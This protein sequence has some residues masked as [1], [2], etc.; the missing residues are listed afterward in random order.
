VMASSR[1]RSEE[2]ADAWGV[3]QAYDDVEQAAAS[4][5]DVV[6]I[7]TPNASHERTTITP[8]QQQAIVEKAIL[9]Q[10]DPSDNLLMASTGIFGDDEERIKETIKK[11]SDEQLIQEWVTVMHKTP[12]GSDSLGDK[13]A[14]WKTAREGAPIQPQGN[15]EGEQPKRQPKVGSPEWK[16]R[17]AFKCH[18]L[19]TSD[20]FEDLLLKY[21]GGLFADDDKT[22]K[23]EDRVRD[24][25]EWLEW[26]TIVRDRIPNLDRKK[27]ASGLMADQQN[28]RKYSSDVIP[29]QSEASCGVR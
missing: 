28:A 4:D 2:V 11:A 1:A 9:H 3:P 15:G 17:T 7:C 26:R 21:T 13:Y 10:A 6:H 27:I 8:E 12:S 25:K 5:A 14:A 29:R 23:G 24:N 16:A 20:V 22:K 19:D 18:V